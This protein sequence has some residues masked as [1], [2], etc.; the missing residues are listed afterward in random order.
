MNSKELL[1]GFNKFSLINFK[2][3]HIGD[4]DYYVKS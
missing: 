3:P 4:L 2:W 1:V